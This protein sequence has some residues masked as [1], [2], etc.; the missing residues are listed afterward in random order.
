MEILTRLNYLHIAP[1]KVRAVS[2]LIRGRDVVTARVLL[3]NLQRRASLPFLKLLNSAVSNAKH[4]FDIDEKNLF[5]SSL[6]VNGGP[7]AKRSRARAFGR[8]SMIRKR[9]SH[10]TMVLK[11]TNAAKNKVKSKKAPEII[12]REVADAS[13]IKEELKKTDTQTKTRDD[14]TKNPAKGRSEF[15]RR[16]FRRKAI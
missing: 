16:L 6:T 12:I 10:I 9:T 15:V 8:A 7:V 14:L 4:N 13:E 1:R 5:I 3:K 11:E 2:G